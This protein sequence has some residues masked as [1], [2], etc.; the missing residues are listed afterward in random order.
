MWSASQFQY[1]FVVILNENNGNLF[2]KTSTSKQRTPKETHHTVE[3]LIETFKNEL[4]KEKQTQKKLP[5]SNP[6]QKRNKSSEKLKL[7]RENYYY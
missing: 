2:I 1:I 7:N 5:K 3:I 6:T 4:R